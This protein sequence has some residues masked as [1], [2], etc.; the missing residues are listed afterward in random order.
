[1]SGR[2]P[3]TNFFEAISAFGMGIILVF[4][5]MELRYRIPALGTFM[6][7]LVLLLMAPA[8][9]TSREIA[10]LNPILKSAWLGIHTSLALL[11]DAAFAF[12][13][14]VSVMYLLQE[15]QLKH[16]HLGAIF[17]RLP[18]LD[19]MDTISYRALSFGWPLFT[20][21]M[22]TGSI[23]AESAWGSYW[24]WQPKETASLLVWL[25]YLALLHLRTIG[26]RGR[27]MAWLSIV[28]F[29]FVLVSFFV[30]SRIGV[31]KHTF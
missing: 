5:I 28:G 20:L 16:K 4:L 12:A 6:L 13:F 15:R 27:K 17:H 1:E 29:V 8:A 31:G 2:I 30:V 22:I 26:W 21:G 10:G 19:V 11:G 18:P 24:S 3:V 23:W 14:I 9:I 7:P 25:L